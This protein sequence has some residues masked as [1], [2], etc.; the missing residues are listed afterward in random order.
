MIQTLQFN[1]FS[2]YHKDYQKE[3]SFDSILPDIISFVQKGGDLSLPVLSE[4]PSIYKPDY[5]LTNFLN[6]VKNNFENPSFLFQLLL[7]HKIDLY[8]TFQ[9]NQQTNTIIDN[10]LTPLVDSRYNRESNPGGLSVY[11]NIVIEAIYKLID[12]IP[13]DLEILKNIKIS[14]TQQSSY[15][16]NPLL[17]TLLHFQSAELYEYIFQKKPFIKELVN[18]AQKSFIQQFN[19][20]SNSHY[21]AFIFLKNSLFPEYFQKLQQE[22]PNQ[23]YEILSYGIANNHIDFFETASPKIFD[24]DQH[25]SSSLL[26]FCKNSE[27]MNILLQKGLQ[28]KDKNFISDYQHISLENFQLIIDKFPNI[29]KLFEENLENFH[30]FPIPFFQYFLEKEKNNFSLKEKKFD[31][32]HYLYSKYRYKD[33]NELES[34][35]KNIQ[36]F[37][38][39]G[40]HLNYCPKF[41]E[42]IVKERNDG[43]KFLNFLNKN[44]IFDTKSIDVLFY[45]LKS[46]PVK[47][48]LNSYENMITKENL[49]SHI[50]EGYPCWWSLST[51]FTTYRKKIPNLLQKAKNN[52]PFIYFVAKDKNNEDYLEKNATITSNII[53]AK[54]FDIEMF[55][56]HDA[57][58][59]NI[60]H[61][62]FKNHN[63]SKSVHFFEII[64]NSIFLQKTNENSEFSNC[65][66]QLFN[67]KNSEN[68]TVWDYLFVKYSEYADY[69]TNSFIKQIVTASIENIS[70]QQCIADSTQTI[71]EFLITKFKNDKELSTLIYQKSLQ[72]ELQSSNKKSTLHKV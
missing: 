36:W 19:I 31:V 71:A 43:L 66:I 29:R 59:N 28:P 72:E 25:D 48:F 47:I 38:N 67:E 45:V 6:F 50:E 4:K 62:L 24:I 30:Y 68:K 15:F 52:M 64:T 54:P 16:K 69:S 49:S 5:M 11:K 35:Q 26:C 27:M 3:S 53:Q 39:Y 17:Q 60:F 42:T 10:S 40:F 65:I 14:S 18:Q 44:K 34:L 8:F 9:Y 13:N 57:Q 55:S 41:C 46:K 63:L 7:Q 23:F 37:E 22:Y 61:H 20:D 58:N 1:D 51:N 70:V 21:I 2:E 32:I 56:Y 33:S 12:Q